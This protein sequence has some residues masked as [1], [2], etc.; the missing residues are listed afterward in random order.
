MQASAAKPLARGFPAAYYLA[1]GLEAWKA[2][3][4]PVHNNSTAPLKVMRQMQIGA[5][6]L[7]AGLSGRCGMALLLRVAPWNRGGA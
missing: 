2:A 7:L 3:G 4:L 6:K 1:G 5:G